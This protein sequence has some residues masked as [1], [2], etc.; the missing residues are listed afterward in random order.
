MQL[1][2]NLIKTKFL[3]TGPNQTGSVTNNNSELPRPNRFKHPNCFTRQRN[4]DHQGTSLE[5]TVASSEMLPSV[6]LSG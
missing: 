4:L 1:G 6:V 5:F 3:T 2:L